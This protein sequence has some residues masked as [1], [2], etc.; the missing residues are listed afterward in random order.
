VLVEGISDQIGLK[1]A[2]AGHS[3]DLD[4][5]RTVPTAAAS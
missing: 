5:V 4:A 2:A 1:T 3:R